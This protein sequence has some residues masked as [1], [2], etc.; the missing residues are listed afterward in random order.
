MKRPNQASG[1]PSNSRPQKQVPAQKIQERSGSRVRANFWVQIGFTRAELA[2]L[3]VISK[4]FERPE[5]RRVS[6]AA[7]RVLLAGLTQWH[8]IEPE[9]IATREYALTE[10]FTTFEDYADGLIQQR[11]GLDSSVLHGDGRSAKSLKRR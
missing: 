2:A 10:G 6:N 7:R 5:D 3:R 11:F 4:R 1:K 9:D 8:E